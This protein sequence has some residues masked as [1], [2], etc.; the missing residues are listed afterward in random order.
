MFNDELFTRSAR[1]L[2]PT[3]RAIEMQAELIRVLNNI[4]SL[5][6]TQQVTPNQFDT[7]INICVVDYFALPILPDLIA[8]TMVE[9][10]RMSIK[11]SEDTDNQEL[12]LAQGKVDMCIF[13][14]AK[15]TSDDFIVDTIAYT[16]PVFLVRRDHPLRHLKKVTWRDIVAYPEVAIKV[17]SQENVRA[18]W[19]RSRLLRFLK[20]SSIVVQGSDYLTA[21]QI[22]ARTDSFMFAPRFS[23]DFI[24]EMDFIGTISLPEPEGSQ[25]LE[26]NLM[27]HIR[28]RNTS[29]HV[30]L[31][32]R[33]KK[34]YAFQQEKI[35]IK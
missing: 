19:I 31:R 29:A 16:K 14:G 15:N 30:W 4:E 25:I 10:P 8:Q 3:P 26:V 11:I 2:V 22:L 7:Q 32:D 12:D 9:A 6:A 24:K 1:S 23:L 21:L 33:I 28:T 13:G 18:A 17:P 27:Y 35:S 5:V 34:I 20:L